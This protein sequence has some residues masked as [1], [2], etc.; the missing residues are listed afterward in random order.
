[1]KKNLLL[2]NR[3]TLRNLAAHDSTLRGVPGGIAT[4]SI[5]QCGDSVNTNPHL[6]RTL[7]VLMACTE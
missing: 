5:T 6:C 7:S 3:E 4:T 1:M 2:L